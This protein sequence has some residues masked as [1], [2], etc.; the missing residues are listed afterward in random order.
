MSENA[1][2][3]PRPDGVSVT[4][5]L[6]LFSIG[7]TWYWNPGSP[8]APRATL[9]GGLGWGGGGVQQVFLRHGMISRDTTGWGA[10][11]TLSTGLPEKFPFPSTTVNATIPDWHGIPLPWKAK[12]SS[13]ETGAA[14]PGFGVTYTVTPQDVSD[15]ILPPA[16]G[17]EDELSPFT[18]SLQSGLGDIGGR[19]DPAVPFLSPGQQNPLGN[20]M[21]GRGATYTGANPESKGGAQAGQPS[22]SVL[23]APAIPYLPPAPQDRPGGL[24]GMMIDAGY[25][26]PPNLYQPAS[27]GLAGLIQDYLHNGSGAGQ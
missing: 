7:G 6:G 18:R 12:V 21:V 16:M 13:V 15:A 26:D 8:T 14:R 25:I 5:P 9:T 23:R 20:G 2:G 17:P 11:G 27:G 24:L 4:L 22:V 19:T 10:S 3:Q 1:K